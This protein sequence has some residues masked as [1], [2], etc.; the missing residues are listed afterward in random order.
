MERQRSESLVDVQ[1]LAL[2]QR[3]HAASGRH[4][5]RPWVIDSQSP[6]S[7]DDRGSHKSEA[8]TPHSRKPFASWATSPRA[9]RFSSGLS[10][11]ERICTG[12]AADQDQIPTPN[13]EV[14][15]NSTDRALV[16]C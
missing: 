3:L 15:P 16:S 2:Q 12:G 8:D 10:T 5:P 6:R 11:A 7:A 4:T 14:T 13:G 9:S 1:A